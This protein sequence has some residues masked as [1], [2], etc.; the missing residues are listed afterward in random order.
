[1]KGEEPTLKQRLWLGIYLKTGNAT[2]AAVQ[3]YDVKDRNSASQIGWEN[4]RKLDYTE[5][6][7]EAGITD[8]LLQQR[9]MEGLSATKVVSARVTG[10]E[11]DS[12][13]DDFI[14]VED[15]LTRHKY[16]ETA[17]KLKKRLTDKLD[18]TSGGK[19]IPILDAISNNNSPQTDTESNQTD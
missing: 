9:I 6:M 18:I 11:A 8:K 3:V 13:T 2:E 19:P 7:E 17:L 15:Y 1:M 10:K 14:D 5:F 16:L 4:L 12:K